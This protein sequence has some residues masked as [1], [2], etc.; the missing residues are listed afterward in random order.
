MTT[1]DHDIRV[2]AR[3]AALRASSDGDDDGPPWRFSGVAVAA[4]DIL[5]MKDGT[6]VLF[7]EENLRA[8]A[9]TQAGEPLTKDHPEDDQG[10]PQYPPPTEETI[11]KVS[12]AGWLDSVQGVGYEATTHDET[13]AK[14]VQAE[15]FDVSVHPTFTL[16]DQDPET[17]A[18][19]AETIK[20]RDLSVVSKGDSPSNSAQWG[21]NQALAS[22]TQTGDLHRDLIAS[23]TGG[24]SGSPG[25]IK[26]TVRGTLEA[27]GITPSDLP[28]DDGPTSDEPAE[29]G[30]TTSESTPMDN[31]DDI[32]TELAS[33]HDLSEEWLED[34][35]D[36]HLT[37]LH[38]SLAG[39][40]DTSTDTDTQDG[41]ADTTDTP[42][43]SGTLADMTVD[44]LADGLEK[45]GFV[46]EAN[47][48]EVVAQAT[49]QEAKARKV[50]EIIANSEDYDE[51]DR[52]DLLASADSLVDHEHQRITGQA[53]AHLPAGAGA[54]TA[55]APGGTGD[56]D[57]LEAYGTGV[58]GADD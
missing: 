56:E 47:A 16:G 45:R 57:G 28:T 31:R 58:Q 4:G 50:E 52:E 5:H 36:D 38:E 17:G 48:D 39:D 53:G 33:E 40:N 43:G 30:T 34:A 49:E 29:S 25:V 41:G 32:I 54:L 2:S 21:P 3:T 22:Y 10:Q 24:G 13:I 46:T 9:E 11:G 27:V 6:P 37:T 19:T 7:T 15:S 14:G 1:P 23:T 20:F 44:D 42:G 26:S 18:Y 51:D 55:S 8:A 12:K 35:D